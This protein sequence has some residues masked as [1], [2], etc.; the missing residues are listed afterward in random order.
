MASLSEMLAAHKY[1]N[2]T[3]P[4]TGT[5]GFGEF[6]NVM[7]DRMKE[8]EDEKRRQAN[9]KKQMSQA[10]EV[11]TAMAKM[12]DNSASAKA[13]GSMT[14]DVE[15]RRRG[16]ITVDDYVPSQE[17][18]VGEDGMPYQKISIKSATPQ[19]QKAQ[20]E[21]KKSQVEM[22]KAQ[23][24]SDLLGAY[25]KGQVQEGAILG[26]MATLGITAE[27]FDI[28]S[29]AK[30]RMQSVG[31]IAPQL[32][33]Q[34][35]QPQMSMAQPI[36]AVGHPVIEQPKT[37]SLITSKP[38]TF[39]KDDS[40]AE[41]RLAMDKQKFE[42]E[43]KELDKAT[44]AKREAAIDA[45]STSL[46]AIDH[47]L[48][49]KNYFGAIEGRM[50]AGLNTGKREWAKNYDFLESKNILNVLGDMKSQSR[51]GATGF[52]ALNEKEL[53]IIQNA[54]MRLDKQLDEKTAEKYLLE[55]KSAFQ[56]IIDREQNGYEN[57]SINKS[58][59]Q[60]NSNDVRSQYN[61]LRASGVSAEEAKRQLGL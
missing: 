26:E 57:E 15:K 35:I 28:A 50:P 42:R 34:S 4:D 10:Q 9:V 6:A 18:G 49:N 39:K 29:Q 56:K 5:S 48:K 14:D 40:I 43:T 37:Q 41:Q 31:Q 44:Q 54:S 3:A 12:K 30:Q 46:S 53:A 61:S 52:G 1:I 27:E 38:F 17:I 13:I 45:A 36:E 8:Q 19:E 16:V 32:V 33:E 21:M 22:E 20:F 55:M 25:I 11:M 59:A 58:Q 24:K 47:L 23:A 7:M 60:G 2:P 51:T